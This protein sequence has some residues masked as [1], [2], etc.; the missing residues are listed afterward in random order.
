[1]FD[2][3]LSPSCEVTLSLANETSS[4]SG[5]DLNLSGWTFIKNL[6]KEFKLS[7]LGWNSV[8]PFGRDFMSDSA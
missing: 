4:P 2:G 1:M 6:R 7:L 8:T 3:T 5:E